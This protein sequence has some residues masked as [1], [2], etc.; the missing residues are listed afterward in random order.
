MLFTARNVGVLVVMAGLL[1]GSGCT[2]TYVAAWKQLGWES[3]DLLVDQVQD[4]RSR[5]EAAKVEFTSAL[6]QFRATYEF[7]G[8]ELEDAYKKLQKS[9]DRC[10]A[11]ADDFRD[12]IGGVKRLGAVFFKE[13][14]SDI[15]EQTVPEYKKAMIKQ[16]DDTQA[17]FDAMVAKMDEAA[18]KM[19]PVLE[20]FKG[21]VIFLKSS[22]NAQALATL[23]EN[24]DELVDGI[25][26]LIAEMNQSIAE[27][28][29]FIAAMGAG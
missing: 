22:L 25:E 11:Q 16:R 9:Y 21:R 10:Y 18:D 29:E 17:S 28:D 3:R 13:W 5:Q 4:T 20:S 19:D 24:A 27:A 7:D 8:G 14:E 6:D 2:S 23:Q 26:A 15:E 1:V 12:E